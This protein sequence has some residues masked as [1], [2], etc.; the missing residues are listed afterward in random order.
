MPDSWGHGG[1][2]SQNRPGKKF[3]ALKMAGEFLSDFVVKDP[4][5]G[6]EFLAP[7]EVP[8]RRPGSLP[9]ASSWWGYHSGK[10]VK[11]PHVF[12]FCSLEN[13][14]QQRKFYKKIQKRLVFF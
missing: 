4:S 14:C 7:T 3:N 12:S 10:A 13:S 11:P 1:Q 5:L 2:L 8:K 9:T 6:C